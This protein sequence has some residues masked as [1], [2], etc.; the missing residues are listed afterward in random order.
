MT[1]FRAPSRKLLFK[2]AT[3]QILLLCASSVVG[4]VHIPAIGQDRDLRERFL[5]EA[6]REWRAYRLFVGRLQ[7]S[8]RVRM[9]RLPEKSLTAEAREDIR[10]ADGCF[11]GH[12]KQR[13]TDGGRGDA[14]HVTVIN[15]D[16]A[17]E[18]RRPG[19]DAAWSLAKLERDIEGAAAPALNVKADDGI[20]IIGAGLV[21]RNMSLPDLVD[22]P[23]FNLKSASRVERPG[24]DWVRI[25]YSYDPPTINGN[26]PV[27]GGWVILDA[28]RHWVVRG[29]E[30]S[31]LY[32]KS[33]G[34]V[35]G[36]LDIVDDPAGFPIV[37]HSSL[38]EW[39][40]PTG[41]P[42]FTNDYETT[43]DYDVHFDAHV[44][45]TEFRLS[46]YGLPEPSGGAGAGRSLGI[47]WLG[48]ATLVCMLIAVLLRRAR[49]RWPVGGRRAVR[50][51]EA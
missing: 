48:L 21:I 2:P 1:D 27:R 8:V 45:A 41:D 12:I 47:V 43:T 7:G 39:G 15:R 42:P 13:I 24:E 6:P 51:A 26:R 28:K 10:Q 25:D 29:F 14:D 4:L 9:M 3:A 31:V 40:S 46:A 17:F 34:S 30:V 36:T 32:K 5:D 35:H 23:E 16:Y 49:N 50:D 33:K 37:T 11:S 44:P 22:A 20:A 19:S 18:L 38:H